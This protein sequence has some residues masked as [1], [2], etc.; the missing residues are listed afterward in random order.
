MAGKFWDPA[1]RKEGLAGGLHLLALRVASGWSLRHLINS[2]APPS[3]GNQTSVY[4]TNVSKWTGITDLDAPLLN[5]IDEP[6][7]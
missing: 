3:D 5:L 4:L 7:Q 6:P 2:W 1:S